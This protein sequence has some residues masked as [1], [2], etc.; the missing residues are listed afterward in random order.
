[1]HNTRGSVYGLGPASSP[2]G[3]IGGGRLLGGQ[4]I[5]ALISQL[6]SAVR[7]IATSPGR[8]AFIYIVYF[9]LESTY[10]VF[11]IDFI[12]QE[13]CKDL[14][15][16]NLKLSFNNLNINYFSVFQT[17]MLLYVAT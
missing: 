2:L 11:E 17:K 12:N 5:R 3:P 16:F 13:S 9:L 1:M 14:Y 6:A 10:S 8:L 15:P 7:A 4:S